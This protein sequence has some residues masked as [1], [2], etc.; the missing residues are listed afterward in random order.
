MP[1]EPQ[2]RSIPNCLAQFESSGV[3]E[4]YT[5]T[6]RPHSQ[7]SGILVPLHSILGGPI[8]VLSDTLVLK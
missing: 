6:R 2:P 3:R 8:L 5:R 4:G 7:D 1:A